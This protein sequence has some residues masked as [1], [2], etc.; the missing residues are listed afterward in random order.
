[1]PLR[2]DVIGEMR[3]RRY[4][5]P[6]IA[7]GAHAA[8]LAREG[9]QEVVPA[10]RVP[11]AGQAMGEDATFEIAAEVA[12]DV[13]GERVGVIAFAMS[14]HEPSLEV[15]LD[16][17]IQQRAFGPPPAIWGRVARRGWPLR[18]IAP[19]APVETRRRSG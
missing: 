1:M 8:L 17:A 19:F 14:Q 11:R 5:A 2:Q 15:T 13:A 3:C 6:G 16:G 4:H 10:L 12:L 9:D 18:H 7:R